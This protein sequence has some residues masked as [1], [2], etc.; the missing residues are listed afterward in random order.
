MDIDP[1]RVISL[2]AGGRSGCVGRVAFEEVYNLG[3]WERCAGFSVIFT[4]ALNYIVVSTR[5]DHDKTSTIQVT[6]CNR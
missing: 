3:K 5:K 6:D 2:A 4:I 1:A